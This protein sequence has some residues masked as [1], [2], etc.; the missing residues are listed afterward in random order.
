MSTAEGGH[1]MVRK[2]IVTLGVAMA[3]LSAPL[4]A[5]EWPQFRGPNSAGLV[6]ESTFPAEWSADKNVAWKVKIPGVAWSSP[7]AWGDKVFVTTAITDNQTKPKPGGGFG[8]FGGPDGSGGPGPGAGGPGGRGGRGRGG[9]GERA[10]GGGPGGVGAPFQ[11]GQSLP[12][13]LQQRLNL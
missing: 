10:L 1:T 11:P 9:P 4:R 8:G 3:A 5:D 2:S 12:P 7:I 13:F 6:A